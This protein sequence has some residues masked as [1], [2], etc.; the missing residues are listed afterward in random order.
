MKAKLTLKDWLAKYYPTKANSKEARKDPIGHSLRKW[1]GLREKV[2]EQ[3]GLGRGSWG[4]IKEDWLR[5]FDIDDLT[6]ALCVKY[7][8]DRLDDNTSEGHFAACATCP[9]SLTLGRPCD[10]GKTEDSPYKTWCD[11]GD[12]EPMIKALVKTRQKY[13]NKVSR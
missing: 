2:L 7:K 12:A 13:G 1:R 8:N 11:T 5:T 6:C 10:Y 3:Y 9:L 4:E